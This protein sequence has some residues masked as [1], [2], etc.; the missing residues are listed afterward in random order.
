ME[1]RQD[2]VMELRTSIKTSG[3]TAVSGEG[4]FCNTSGGAFTVT[5]PASPSVGD[6]VSIKDYA[7]TF[8]SNNL[9]LGR[10]SSNMVVQQSMQLYRL[11]DLGLH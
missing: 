8:D 10:N 7:N 9:T 11:K 1:R 6:I 2:L 4:Y 5:L 3:F